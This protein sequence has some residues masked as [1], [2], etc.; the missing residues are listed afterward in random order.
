MSRARPTL[1]LVRQAVLDVRRRPDHRSELINQLLLGEGVRIRRVAGPTGWDAIEGLEDGYTGW[2]RGWGLER[3]SVARLARWRREAR[4]RIA[5]PMTL[6]RERPGSGASLGPLP[7]MG[8]VRVTGRRGA[9]VRVALPGGRIGWTER[10]A[11][12]G[13]REVPGTPVERVRTVLGAPYLWGGR[14]VLGMDCSGLIQLIAGEQGRGL[15]RDAHDQWRATRRLR[16]S[17]P[18]SP[19]DLVF[20]SSRPRGRVEHV[21]VYA[22]GGAY[23]HA[24]GVVRMN[25]F[26]PSNQLFDKELAAQLRGFGRIG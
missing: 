24:R 26:D 17:D 8:R 13:A 11:L 22:G 18:L 2:V 4:H 3:V 20:F 25:S 1:A 5:V 21:A 6:L 9:W 14:T 10:S 7:W 15:P 23:L 19:G 16:E 12:R